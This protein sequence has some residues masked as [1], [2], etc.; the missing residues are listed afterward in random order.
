MLKCLKLGLLAKVSSISPSRMLPWRMNK[1]SPELPVLVFSIKRHHTHLRTDLDSFYSHKG[2]HTFGRWYVTVLIL[3]IQPI[4]YVFSAFCGII[5]LCES[6]RCFPLIFFRNSV[7]PVS[8]LTYTEAAKWLR[9]K[10]HNAAVF[11]K[12]KNPNSPF[13]YTGLMLVLLHW[14]QHSS[15][16]PV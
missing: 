13:C 2:L 4:K 6:R 7:N 14:L 1:L 3:A 15:L 16:S 11:V 8:N 12:D 10:L 9:K 5:V